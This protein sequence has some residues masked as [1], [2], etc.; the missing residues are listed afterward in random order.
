MRTGRRNLSLVGSEDLR[1][2]AERDLSMADNLLVIFK[3]YLLI[4]EARRK[5]G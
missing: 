1:I 2:S 5:A 4:N 3:E